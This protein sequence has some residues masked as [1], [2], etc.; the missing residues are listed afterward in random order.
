MRFWDH[1]GP[2]RRRSAKPLFIS[3]WTVLIISILISCWS[4]VIADRSHDISSQGRKAICVEIRFLDTSA[5]TALATARATKNPD[6]RKARVQ[7]AQVVAKLVTDLR[8]L[9]IDCD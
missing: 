2:E 3:F 6:I 8:K 7:Q 1:D 9:E 4:L 5:Q